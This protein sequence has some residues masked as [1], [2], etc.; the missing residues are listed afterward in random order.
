VTLRAAGKDAFATLAAQLTTVLGVSPSSAA[1][2][3]ATWPLETPA[4]LPGLHTQLVLQEVADADTAS[5]IYEVGFWVDKG[6]GGHADSPYG[7]I[8]WTPVP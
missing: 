8:V 2:G 6:R 1:A 3:S 4:P 5:G 7:R